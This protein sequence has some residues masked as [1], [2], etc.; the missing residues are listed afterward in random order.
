MISRRVHAMSP[1]CLGLFGQRNPDGLSLG[2][3]A[4]TTLRLSLTPAC[5]PPLHAGADDTTGQHLAGGDGRVSSMR[6]PR[7]PAGRARGARRVSPCWLL[8]QLP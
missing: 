2:N 3:A 5:G 4:A 7:A 8:Q 6:M 1:L